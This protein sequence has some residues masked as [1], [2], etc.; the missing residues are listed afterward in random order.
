MLTSDLVP[1]GCTMTTVG[2]SCEV[3]LMLRGLVDIPK[4]V[5]RLDTKIAGLDTNLVRLIKSI[6]IENYEDK[7][8]LAC[9]CVHVFVLIYYC[10]L[11][12]VFVIT[13]SC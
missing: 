3:H 5:G 1:E 2:A 9:V 12:C 4:E 11:K 13:G 8:S 10:Y 7:V 6:S